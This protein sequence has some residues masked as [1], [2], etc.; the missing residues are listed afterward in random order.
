MW[1]LKHLRKQSSCLGNGFW[2]AEVFL[3]NQER[4]GDYTYLCI[5]LLMIYISLY[6]IYVYMH[7]Y[8]VNICKYVCGYLCV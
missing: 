7:V 3:P 1:A 6:N 8:A 4:S 5:C 2:N